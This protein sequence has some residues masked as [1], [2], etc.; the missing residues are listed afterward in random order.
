MLGRVI[1][2]RADASAQEC[3]AVFEPSVHDDP[4][5]TGVWTYEV[6]TGHAAYFHVTA[7]YGVTVLDAVQHATV[8][9]PFPVTV[10]L[11]PAGSAPI[12]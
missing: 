12:G 6:V 5:V 11:Y 4:D 10:Y 2:H 9:W 8:T 1:D 3:D 7:L